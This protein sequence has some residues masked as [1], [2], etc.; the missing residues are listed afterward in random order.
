M[1][2]W[3]IERIIGTTGVEHCVRGSKAPPRFH[4]QFDVPF[5][6]TDDNMRKHLCVMVYRVKPDDTWA[7]VRTDPPSTDTNPIGPMKCNI[8][9]K[10][11]SNDNP[12]YSTPLSN[13]GNVCAECADCAF[14]SGIMFA[15]PCIGVTT[16]NM[17][18]FAAILRPDVAW[19]QL[20]RIEDCN[21][22]RM[23]MIMDDFAKIAAFNNK[24]I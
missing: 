8:C 14:A 22:A 1:Q 3:D 20:P 9:S 18:S 7:T 10:M 2:S 23:R 5:A 17:S 4:M 21:R 13:A 24:I 16:Y 12:I 15:D 11:S 6:D 19:D